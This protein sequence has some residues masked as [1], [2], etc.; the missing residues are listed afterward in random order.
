MDKKTK[1]RVVLFGPSLTAVSGV[2][3]HVNMLIASDLARSFDLMH[4]QVGSEGRHETRLQKLVRFLISPFHLTL[5]LIRYRPAIVHMNTSLDQKAYWRDLVYLL[6]AKLLGRRVVNQIHG[7]PFPRDFFPDNVLLTWILKRMLL[8]SD[9]VTVLS[10]SELIAYQAF[11]NRINVHLVP[12]A[13][14]PAG[15]IDHPRMLNRDGPLRLVYVGRLVSAKGL[16][17]AIDALHLL[18]KQGRIFTFVIAGGGADEARLQQTVRQ[19]GLAHCVRFLGGVFNEAKKRLWLDSDVFVFPSYFEGLPY[20]LLESMAA[21]CVPITTRVAAIPDVIQ[22][23][24][25]GLFVPIKDAQALASAI[26]RLDD[27]RE[28]LVKMA[29]NCRKR[30]AEQY[31]VNRLAADF[32]AIYRNAIR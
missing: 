25:Q 31:T 28:Q 7:G 13:I 14:N 1:P 2:S 20:S 26:A 16:F 12:N 23:G 32:E 22:D 4:F 8:L 21:G 11:D 5:F 17:D 18:S 3:T 9:A 29:G 27:D 10:S 30:I 6:V 24:I 19:S 15:L